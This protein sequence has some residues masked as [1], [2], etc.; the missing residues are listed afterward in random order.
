MKET[1]NLKKILFLLKTFNDF[2]CTQDVQRKRGM[3]SQA[4]DF[5]SVFAPLV[6]MQRLAL[7]VRKQFAITFNDFQ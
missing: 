4:F 2:K 6:F 5:E 1:R 7:I 3:Q